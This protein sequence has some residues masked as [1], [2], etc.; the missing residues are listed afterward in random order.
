MILSE[1]QLFK[2]VIIVWV[3]IL[4]C[5][6]GYLIRSTGQIRVEVEK[7]GLRI[8]EFE[9]NLCLERTSKL[10]VNDTAQNRHQIFVN[11]FLNSI[12]KGQFG[13]EYNKKF[14]LQESETDGT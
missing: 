13:I 11:N 7:R 14:K 6:V 10:E 4:S 9:G 8:A 5:L 12:T 2:R 3:L 1:E